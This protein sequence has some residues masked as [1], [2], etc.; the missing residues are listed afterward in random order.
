MKSTTVLVDKIA[1][2][3]TNGMTANDAAVE[4]KS[5]KLGLTVKVADPTAN[6]APLDTGF[7]TISMKGGA[8]GA[9]PVSV[10]IKVLAY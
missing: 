9:V 10:S 7:G 1:S 4:L 8:A 2:A 3:V 5:D 6:P